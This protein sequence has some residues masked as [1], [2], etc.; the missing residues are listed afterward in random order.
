MKQFK[1]KFDAKPIERKQSPKIKSKEGAT[2]KS[3]ANQLAE[4]RYLY[5]KSVQQIEPRPFGAHHDRGTPRVAKYSL[6]DRIDHN[7]KQQ[8][9]LAQK[10][11]IND[12]NKKNIEYQKISSRHEEFKNK[13]IGQN[14]TRKKYS[15]QLGKEDINMNSTLNL[16]KYESFANNLNNEGYYTD[17]IKISERKQMG[18][19]LN[20]TERVMERPK[21]GEDP[22]AHIQSRN[23]RKLLDR[24]LNNHS[25]SDLLEFEKYFDKINEDECD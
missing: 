3:R 11:K 18:R 6:R 4:Q 25:L 1:S 13:Y 5:N 23:R 10:Q 7:N 20:N 12:L 2:P 16:N 22:D 14:F 15:M 8:D 21:V 19:A 24:T 17:R 9:Y